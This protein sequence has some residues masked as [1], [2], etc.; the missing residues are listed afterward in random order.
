MKGDI[1]PLPAAADPPELVRDR[2]PPE[3]VQV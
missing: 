1:C 2:D 3:F